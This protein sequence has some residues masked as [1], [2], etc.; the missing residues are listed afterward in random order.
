[1]TKTKRARKQMDMLHGPLTK[2]ILLFAM[3]LAL[4]GIL[5]QLFS[6]ADVAV[7]NYFD[8]VA[9]QSAV[10]STVAL[11]NLLLNLFQ[12]LS[13]GA[14]VVIAEYIGK[15]KT[16]DIHSVV[17]TSMVI[18]VVSGMILLGVGIGVSKPLLEVMDTPSEVLDNATL[19]LRIYFIGMPFLMVFNFGAAVLR[20]VGDNNKTLLILVVTGVLNLGLNILFV[21]AFKM[22]V[23]GVATATVFANI[24][25]AVMIV[26]FLM[27]NDMFRIRKKQSRIRAEYVKK[28]FA[29]GLPAGI[30]GVVFSVANVC[31]Q[32]AVNGFGTQAVAGN[33][34]AVNF[35]YY[36]Y[37]FISAFA[38]TTVTFFGQNYAAGEY[39]RCKRIFLLNML[40]AFVISTVLSF[41]FTLGGK[42]FI[43]IYTSD[44]VAIDFALKRM[45][46]ALTGMGI[47]CLY[48]IAGGALRGMGRSMLPAVFTVLG[49]CILRIVWV[50]TV[51]A[52]YPYFWVLMIIY[53]ISWLITGAAMLV[54]YFI[55]AHKAFKTSA[56]AEE[57]ANAI[58]EENESPQAEIAQEPIVATECAATE[59]ENQDID[60]ESSAEEQDNQ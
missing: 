39:V 27:R 38:Q 21:A 35:E 26:V 15:K 13:V 2:N 19:Y 54:A 49:S 8:G 45:W 29:I 56:A 33:G 59:D 34:D 22:S 5:Q 41:V 52:A 9:A 32:T 6:S 17:F 25:C 10:N 28:I 3:P 31:I 58:A 11:I 1:M 48:E 50:Y 57:N 47:A 23:A 36:A 42:G 7:I 43:R 14:T 40:Y 51:F 16:D 60:T 53:P 18:A 20:S 30:Q 37:F 46:S 24:V 12:G 4:S 55:I 44:E